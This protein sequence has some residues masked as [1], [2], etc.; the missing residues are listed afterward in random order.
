M[1]RILRTA[2]RVLWIALLCAG[3]LRL[4]AWADEPAHVS[5]DP[6]TQQLSRGDMFIIQVRIEDV[7]DM[8]GA[9]VSLA[10]DPSRLQIQF[11][12]PGDLFS[13]GESTS[14]Y[15]IDNE[16]GT[17]DYAVTL[18]TNDPVAGDGVLCE[19]RGRALTL[20]D[21][22]VT[23]TRAELADSQIHL[24]PVTTTDG[25]IRVGA[26]RAYLPLVAIAPAP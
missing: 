13:P 8:L 23:I 2:T 14:F 17:L 21:A 19:I 26:G 7:S 20:G 24:I 6:A 18:L 16:A 1:N 22:P 3:A 4:A 5:L 12:L 10:F 11:V 15:T 25:M 9:D